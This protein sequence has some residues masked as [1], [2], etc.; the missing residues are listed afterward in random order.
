MNRVHNDK[1]PNTVQ[2]VV[3]QY[4]DDVPQFSPVYDGRIYEVVITDDTFEAVKQVLEGVDYS[5]GALFFIARDA[6][7]GHNI[8]WFDTDLKYLFRHGYHEFYTFP[9]EKETKESED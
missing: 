6:A 5:K 1:F 7:E 9:T 3:F 4:V 2:D 8:N